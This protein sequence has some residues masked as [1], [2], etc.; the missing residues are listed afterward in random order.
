MRFK[1]IFLVVLFLY[2]YNISFI[3][4]PSIISTRIIIGFL[5]LVYF[6]F[7]RYSNISKSSYILILSI[8]FILVPTIITSVI[9]N[10][11]DNRFVGYVFQ[12]ILY[13]FGA[14]YIVRFFKIKMRL[15]LKYILFLVC[16]HNLLTV[17]MFL[18]PAFGDFITSLQWLNENEVVSNVAEFRSRFIGIGWGNFFFGGVICSVALII[19][20]HIL[21]SAKGILKTLFYILSYIFIAITGMYIARITLV[22]ISLSIVYLLYFFYRNNFKLFIKALVYILLLNIIII[23]YLYTNWYTL[24]SNSAFVHSF[25]LLINFIE[26]GRFSTSSTEEVQDMM[27]FPDDFKTL[28]IGDGKFNIENGLY[29]MLT[30]VGY[31]RLLYYFGIIGTLLYFGSHIFIFRHTYFKQYKLLNIFILMLLIISNLKGL[32]DLN[33]FIF[34]FYFSYNYSYYENIARNK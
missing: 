8:L 15:L 32:V 27:I 13:L 3:F 5:G 12:N 31:S 21:F 28:V 10:H 18:V 34:L 16:F 14:F 30:D 20:I 29:Y 1:L 26:N 33:W 17:I 24:K 23:S 25:E 6:S 9:N 22:G 2:I 7:K 11:F 19:N 4:L